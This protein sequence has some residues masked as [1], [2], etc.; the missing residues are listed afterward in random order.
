MATAMQAADGDLLADFRHFC[1]RHCLDFE[2]VA[3]RGHMHY[4]AEKRMEEIGAEEEEEA[5]AP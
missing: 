4:V 3:D 5:H 2:R 1:A